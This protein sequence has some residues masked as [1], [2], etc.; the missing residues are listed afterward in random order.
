[1]LQLCPNIVDG[2]LYEGE[3]FGG[4]GWEAEDRTKAGRVS[5]VSM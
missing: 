5:A 3:Q 2:G 4:R 1:M